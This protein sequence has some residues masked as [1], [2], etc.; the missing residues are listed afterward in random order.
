[1]TTVISIVPYSF[2]PAR[3]GGQRGI[4]L[5]NKYF[6][7]HVHLVCVSVK[8]N[9]ET[10]AEGYALIKLL[11]NK[12]W[13]YINPL[14]FFSIRKIIRDRA[15]THVLI[16][17]PYYGWLG[18]LL[19]NFLGIKLI[20]HSHNIEALR[21]KAL[22]KPWW[23]ILGAY[24]KFTHRGADYNFFIH[25]EDK[26]YAIDTYNLPPAKCRVVTYGIEQEKPPAT[27][28]I[29]AAKR[30]VRERH[31]VNP[32]EKIL[33]FNGSFNYAPNRHALDIIRFR[34]IPLL[35]Q[36]GYK[37]KIIV[38]GPWVEAEESQHLIVTGFVPNIADYFMSADVFINPVVDGG[39]IKTKLVEALAYNGNAVSTKTGAA[40][41]PL[42]V[43]GSKLL[44]TD[45]HDWEAFVGGIR[46]QAQNDSSIPMAFFEHFNWNNITAQAARFIGE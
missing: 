42:S 16:E 3:I 21:F 31:G 4:A 25:E 45:D 27:D 8:E 15:A 33:F 1:M 12:K 22:G 2:L 9:D 14:Y 40:G 36:Q 38:C 7:R 24:E 18:Y 44:L 43:C 17:H 30:T 39:G 19:K 46:S 10:G 26:K 28:E 23:K 41:V 11:S 34:I 32:D 37:F 29:Q 5:F 13:R 20:V 6:C 35:N